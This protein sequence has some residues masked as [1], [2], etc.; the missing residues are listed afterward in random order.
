MV[1]KTYRYIDKRVAWGHTRVFFEDDGGMQRPVPI[2]FTNAL[3]PDP[4]VMV[5]AGRSR[6]RLQELLEL[7]S[8]VSASA[9]EPGDN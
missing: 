1:G 3:P 4:F 6:L 7:L 8:L 9:E 5:A 2:G